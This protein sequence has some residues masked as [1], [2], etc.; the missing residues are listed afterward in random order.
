MASPEP[1]PGDQVRIASIG[2]AREATVIERVGDDFAV[3]VTGGKRIIVGRERI[4]SVRISDERREEMREMGRKSAEKRR[5]ERQAEVEEEQRRHAERVGR[6]A[7]TMVDA[8]D[9]PRLRSVPKSSMA[10]SEKYLAF[11]RGKKCCACGKPAPSHAHHQGGRGMGQKTDD[12]RTVPLC[13]ICH[14]EWHLRATLPGMD[15]K[16]AKLMML[17]E[18][19]DLLVEFLK[20]GDA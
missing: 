10:R 16:T 12:Y 5:L 11:V 18:Q 13:G 17:T 15:S 1:K 20:T 19:V 3:R 8:D 7:S 2:T 14:H 4:L 6:E 9:L